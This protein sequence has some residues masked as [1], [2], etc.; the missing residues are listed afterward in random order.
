MQNTRVLVKLREAQNTGLSETSLGDAS[1]R[2]AHREAPP[3]FPRLQQ[4]LATRSRGT[5]RNADTMS[6]SARLEALWERTSH[7]QL[8]RLE[9][10]TK[11][12]RDYTRKLPQSWS[13]GSEVKCRDRVLCPKLQ[14]VPYSHLQPQLQG[15]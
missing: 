15:I 14:W 7:V 9:L 10:R 1:L 11:A 13:H 4:F 12:T 3:H 6:P 2:S 8:A 5:G